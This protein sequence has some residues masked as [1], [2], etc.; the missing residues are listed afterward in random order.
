M[1]KFLLLVAAFVSVNF[2]AQAAIIQVN[3]TG[4]YAASWSGNYD[5]R[6]GQTAPGGFGEG[7]LGSGR[8]VFGFVFDTNDARA[9]VSPTAFYTTDPG[10]SCNSQPERAPGFA[11]GMFDEF[12]WSDAT[13]TINNGHIFTALG[14]INS[15]EGAYGQAVHLWITGDNPLLPSDILTPVSIKDFVGSG[16]LTYWYGT[17]G[18]GGGTV[19]YALSISSVDI[20]VDGLSAPITSV[21]EP[22]TWV[23]LILG[24]STIGI[25]VARNRRAENFS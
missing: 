25:S 7:A 15:L 20:V 3:Y 2:S 14:Y 22:T 17:R 5:P 24:F 4:T 16:G 11:T 21:P 13:L 10:C 18:E 8:G 1:L 19:G 6:T 12:F 9:I 23:M